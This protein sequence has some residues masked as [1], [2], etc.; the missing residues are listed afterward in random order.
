VTDS[1]TGHKD[2]Y[3]NALTRQRYRLL[4]ARRHAAVKLCSWT[5][6]S[7]RDRGVCYKE[8]FYGVSCHRCL[9]ITPNIYCN[10]NCLYCW[11]EWEL[12]PRT[13]PDHWDRPEELVDAAV[14][15]QRKLLEGYYGAL[16]KVDRRLL[17]EAQHPTQAAISLAGEPTLYP[18][19]DE[20]IDV[21]HDRGMTTFLVT[22]GTNP[23]CLR[24]LRDSG[25][26]PTQL[27][28]SLDAPDEETH[29]A[30]NVPRMPNSWQRIGESLE[31]LGDLDTRSV[32]RITAIKGWN[33]LDPEAYARLVKRSRAD[34]LEVKSYLAVSYDRTMYHPKMPL[35]PSHDEV[36][37]FAR[38]IGH[39]LGYRRLGEHRIS[40]VALL[41][42]GRVEPRLARS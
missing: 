31:L 8:I 15:G 2:L 1:G 26:L 12:A 20:L 38:A 3:V 18:W 21:L 27:Y 7:L 41:G 19:L 16:D 4:G 24:Q 37:E 22:N 11:R 32:V 35:M 39:H 33:M 13:I 5:R 34:F 40:R 17:D 28:L 42:S 6:K 14:A 30:I 36:C 25:R 10:Q 29:R 9:Q 23:D